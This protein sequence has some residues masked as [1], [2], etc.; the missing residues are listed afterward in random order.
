MKKNIL[1]FACLTFL[2]V[3]VLFSGCGKTFSSKFHAPGTL[4]QGISKVAVLP[5]NDLTGQDKVSPVM[6]NLF[7]DEMTRRFGVEVIQGD[8]L[9]RAL[10]EMRVSPV[11]ISSRAFAAKIAE[12]LGVQA[13]IFG[14]ILEYRYRKWFT[15]TKGMSE[16]PVVCLSARMLNGKTGTVVWAATNVRTS[17]AVFSTGRDPLSGVA[18]LVVRDLVKSIQIKK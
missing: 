12:A 18:E 3:L 1:K 2:A 15:G 13:V 17:Y 10:E 16:D 8:A 4:T 9:N 7:A 6:A 5:F 11:D 14:D